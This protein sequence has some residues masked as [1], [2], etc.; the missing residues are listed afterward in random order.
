MCSDFTRAG[1]RHS[2]PSWAAFSLPLRRPMNALCE[3]WTRCASVE[4]FRAS[5]ERVARVD[6]RSVRAL[7]APCDR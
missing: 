1:N 7:D 5:F 6:E 2:E 3:L 4:R